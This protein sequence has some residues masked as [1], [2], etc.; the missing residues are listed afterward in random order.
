MSAA[1]YAVF[2]FLSYLVAVPSFTILYLPVILLGV[3]PVWFGLPGL[4]GSLIGAAIGGLLVEN[5][6]FLAW[7]E[8]VTTLTIY[9]LNWV[10]TPRDVAEGKPKKLVLLLV[11]YAL[12]LFVSTSFILWQFTVFGL[13][14][15]DAAL[16]FL[17]PTFAINYLIEA[18]I[19]PV[20][21]KTVSPRLKIWGV[22][23][24]NFW[25][26]RNQRKGKV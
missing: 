3:F 10:L 17:L 24:G 23:A 18:A 21:L 25:E 16:V 9:G 14:S 20:L 22:Y 12:T 19:C 2:F 11:V 15:A 13:F 1:L 4:F 7:I 6:G 5:L 8:V 26:W